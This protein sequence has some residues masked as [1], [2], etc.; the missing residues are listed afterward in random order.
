MIMSVIMSA[1][2]AHAAL[3]IN[4]N[5]PTSLRHPAH[6]NHPFMVDPVY[7]SCLMVLI[8]IAIKRERCHGPFIRLVAVSCGFSERNHLGQGLIG[9]M[10]SI[11][12]AWRAFCEPLSTVPAI[13]GCTVVASRLIRTA[14]GLGESGSP[15]R[16]RGVRDRGGSGIALRLHGTRDRGGSGTA[17]RLRGVRD[18]GGSGIALGLHTV[19]GRGGLGT[20]LSLSR[21]RGLCKDSRI[22]GE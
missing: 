11:T 14:R 20:A 19:R 2:S 21:T 5:I 1:G 18:R 22:H 10:A 6:L 8:A 15:L 7:F 12:S 3:E 4:H 13:G 9:I 16:F 17:L